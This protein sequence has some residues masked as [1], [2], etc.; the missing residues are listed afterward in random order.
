MKIEATNKENLLKSNKEIL[1]ID[2]FNSLN[3]KNLALK[4]NIDLDTIH[5]Y[6]KTK[7]ELLII[8]FASI[9][10]EFFHFNF[11]KNSGHFVIFLKN[12]IKSIK[13]NSINKEVFNEKFTKMDL[14]DF[15]FIK[16]F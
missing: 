10:K 8:S 2:G 9:S 14:V 7:K 16:L 6:F 5:N 12:F 11:M 13:N 4:N 3:M 15:T 1:S